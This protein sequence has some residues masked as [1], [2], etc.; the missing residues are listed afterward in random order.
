MRD[1]AKIRRSDSLCRI[2]YLG[3]TTGWVQLDAPLGDWRTSG[4]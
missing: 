1:S 4:T 3:A 2:F